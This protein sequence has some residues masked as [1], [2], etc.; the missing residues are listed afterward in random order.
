MDVLNEKEKY[1]SDADKLKKGFDDDTKKLMDELKDMERHK[2]GLVDAV[3]ER[4][5]EKLAQNKNPIGL[6]KPIV[7][8]IQLN[9]SE[10]DE[11]G[12]NNLTPLRGDVSER[13]KLKEMD[14][15]TI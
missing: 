10:T 9:K 8:K 13:S 14:A 7:E 1:F 6:P 11:I 2:L 4:I 15:S 12:L 3:D 5:D